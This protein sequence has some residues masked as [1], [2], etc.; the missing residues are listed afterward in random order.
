MPATA[1]Q[2]ERGKG[3]L[4]CEGK[5][6]EWGQHPGWAFAGAVPWGMGMVSITHVAASSLSHE[7]WREVTAFFS[8][9]DGNRGKT[10][11]LPSGQAGRASRCP[12]AWGCIVWLKA[13]RVGGH[14]AE[15]PT[16]PWDSGFW[17]LYL[18]PSPAP[19]CRC[20]PRGFGCKP[21]ET[22][23]FPAKALSDGKAPP[24]LSRWV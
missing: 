22:R 12:R 3:S 14:S 6:L 10:R 24:S 11:V 15:H 5:G 4:S 23:P 7:V 13:R 18:I 9:A 17:C 20:G 21:W 19:C 8:P 1:P 2:R 16:T